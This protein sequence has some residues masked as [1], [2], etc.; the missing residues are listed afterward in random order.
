MEGTT[1]S[2]NWKSLLREIHSR[3][4]KAKKYSEFPDTDDKRKKRIVF[5]RKDTFPL[6]SDLFNREFSYTVFWIHL[7]Q[8]H[9]EICPYIAVACDLDN[10][11]LM[12]HLPN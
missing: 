11:E 7:H 9:P 5:S 1:W 2:E 6:V 10:I 12:K 4:L 3:I 8:S